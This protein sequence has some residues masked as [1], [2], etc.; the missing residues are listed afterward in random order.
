MTGMVAFVLKGY[1]RLS[2]TFI[3]QEINA[4]EKRGLNIHIYSLRYPTDRARHPI[5]GEI[6]APIRY[7]PEYLHKEPWRVIRA[8]QALRTKIGYSAAWQCWRAD[9]RR[10]RTRNRIRR[11][12]QALVLAHE[13]PT[14]INHLHAHFLHTP[15]SVARYAALIRGL[16][17]SCSAHAKDIWTSDNWEKSEKLA[18]CAWAVTCT[19]TN[20]NHLTTLAPEGR[21]HLTYHGIDLKRFPSPDA[22]RPAR[23]GSRA[24]DPVTV[25]TVGRAVEKKGHEDLLAA[26]AR[27][28]NTLHWRFEHIG[29]GPLQYRLAQEAERLGIAERCE[30]HGAL[31][32]KEVHAA[33]CRADLFA[34]MSREAADGDRDGL[35][36]VLMEAQSQ[37]LAVLA[38]DISAIPELIAPG[39]NG[40]LVKPGDTVSAARVL[41]RLICEPRLRERLGS[42]GQH[43]V[44][45]K[46]ALDPCIESLAARFGLVDQTVA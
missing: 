22:P 38:T 41:E 25:L 19:K 30:F 16:N 34:L 17:W 21:V 3:A 46:F 40:L 12:G 28:P 26:L 13:M 10:D 15:A 7:L 45:E 32:Q 4:L 42:E 24:A 5:N 11:F 27:L 23:D 2:E 35:P 20:L 31:A 18:D 9:Y 44:H 33:Y 43:R 37:G 14:E 36:N 39:E 6:R 8:W 29:E 1:P